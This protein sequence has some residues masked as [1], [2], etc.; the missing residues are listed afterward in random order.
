MNRQKLYKYALLVQGMY[1]LLTAVW[2]LVDIQSFM[3]ITGPKTD[4]WLVRTVAVL[5]I[6]ISLFFLLSSKKS[7]EPRVTLTALVFSFG[8]AYIDF[9]YTLNNTIRWV[10]ALDGIVESMFGLL[11]LY[12]L[13][14]PRKGSIS[15]Q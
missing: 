13:F 15:Q 3:F 8:L 7:E 14:S 9:Y 4:V 5:L 2:A 1:V 10:Y 12:F 11:W 6:C